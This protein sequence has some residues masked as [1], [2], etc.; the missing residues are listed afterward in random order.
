VIRFLLPLC[1]LLWSTTAS[2]RRVPLDSQ[3]RLHGGLS[4]ADTTLQPGVSVGLDTRLTRLFYVDVGGFYTPGEDPED[5][6]LVLADPSETFTMQHG[7]F[8]TP[9][10]RIPHRYGETF[11]WDLIGRL[12]FGVVWSHDSAAER[13]PDVSDPALTGGADLLLRY[14]R[15][16]L[17]LSG[18]A[19]AWSSFSAPALEEVNML[20]PQ[21]GVEGLYQW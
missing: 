10:L 4:L 21:F 3:I 19:F 6:R 9:G 16:G 1:A 20:R 18:K 13:A 5:Q 15:A 2:A 11:N 14:K 12:G 8:A 7:V 17:R